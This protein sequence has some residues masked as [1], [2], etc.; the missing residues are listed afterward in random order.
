MVTIAYLWLY[1]CRWWSCGKDVD[2]EVA[3][4]ADADDYKDNIPLTPETRDNV[5]ME[6][7]DILIDKADVQIENLLSENGEIT[8]VGLDYAGDDHNRDL[9][10]AL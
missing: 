3:I 8:K 2:A 1:H 10:T 5:Q 7:T 6:R 9:N 4:S